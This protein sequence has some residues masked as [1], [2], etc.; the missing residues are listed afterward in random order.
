M[1]CRIGINRFEYYVLEI[2]P[3][4]LYNVS[5]GSVPETVLNGEIFLPRALRIETRN[6]NGQTGRSRPEAKIECLR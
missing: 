6:A 4:S 3:K 1:E 2:S 5:E